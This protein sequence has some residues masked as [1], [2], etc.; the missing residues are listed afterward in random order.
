MSVLAK[1]LIGIG[2][3]VL[4]FA[5]GRYSAPTRVITETKIVTVEKKVTDTKT[6]TDIDQH[7]KTEIVTIR[8]PD[9]TVE[10][11][12]IITD[13]RQIAKGTDTK[14]KEETSKS[15]DTKKEVVRSS[16]PVTIAL[17]AGTKLPLGPLSQPVY[18]VCVSKPVLGPIA[19][20]V[21]GMNDRT[22]GLSLGISL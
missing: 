17:L 12:T 13:D 8:H 20:G 15:S 9:G 21:W 3:C 18:G 1:V 2:L 5:A 19:V 10:T 11:H 14:T 16:D 22:V 4:L 6:K 7:K